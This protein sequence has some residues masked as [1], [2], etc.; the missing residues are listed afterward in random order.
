MTQ[1]LSSNGSGLPKPHSKDEL[2][3]L[4]E[5]M[6]PLQPDCS[7]VDLDNSSNQHACPPPSD[8]GI[9]VDTW[10]NF[11]DKLG[12]SDD[13]EVGLR[14]A[15]A[16]LFDLSHQF[17][18]M[19]FSADAKRPPLDQYGSPDKVLERLFA[20][21]TCYTNIRPI[22][23]YRGRKIYWGSNPSSEKSYIP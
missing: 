9:W 16:I 17:A 1:K 8:L 22:A 7:V 21:S 14:I 2:I 13:A 6:A 18:N 11:V 12:S 19:L 10:H 4:V 23:I 15:R 20:E 5:R 3:A